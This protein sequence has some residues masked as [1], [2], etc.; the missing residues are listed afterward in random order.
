M[1]ATEIIEI[2]SRRLI[3]TYSDKGCLI[4]FGDQR[5]SEAI[6]PIGAR[7]IYEETNIPIPA[8]DVDISTRITA[9]ELKSETLF[10]AIE[11]GLTL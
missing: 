1:I 6:D 9:L 5:Y 8:N 11:G 3:R 7:R 4:Q 2:N 10:A